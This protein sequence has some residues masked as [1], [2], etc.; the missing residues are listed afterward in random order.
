MRERQCRMVTVILLVWAALYL[1]ALHS[2]HSQRISLLTNDQTNQASSICPNWCPEG[3]LN[4]HEVCPLRIL[5]P[6]RL[7]I[8]PSGRCGYRI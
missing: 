3:D 5:S 6:L 4:P 2:A 7:P 8:S 1:V